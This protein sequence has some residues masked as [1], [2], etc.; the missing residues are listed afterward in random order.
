MVLELDHAPTRPGF[1]PLSLEA[2]AAAAAQAITAVTAA[3]SRDRRGA[4]PVETGRTHIA[5]SEGCRGSDSASG[6]LPYRAAPQRGSSP[7]STTFT[8]SG[9]IDTPQT[10]C[11]PWV[12][13]GRDDCEYE[14]DACVAVSASAAAAASTT[15]PPREFIVAM[16]NLM[17][18]FPCLEQ[19][20]A[21]LKSA[22]AYM[23]VLQV[24]KL[25]DHGGATIL[26]PRRQLPGGSATGSSPQ[27]AGQEDPLLTLVL[28]LDETLVHCRLECLEEPRHDFCVKF[29]ESSA[30]GYV[31]VRP[32]ARLFLDI[33]A[34]LFE[35]VVFTASSRGYADQ[36]LDNL[37][38]DG[39]C[40]AA[41]LYRQHCTEVQGAYLK[42]VRRLGRP[43][44]RIV[45]VDNS[46]VSLTL[47]PDNGIIVKGW[48]A[49][50]GEDSELM[51]LLLVLHQLA[52]S[53][54]PEVFLKHRYGLDEFFQAIRRQPELIGRVG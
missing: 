20:P 49:E 35:V 11:P 15:S 19:Y 52:Q 30:V 27:Y 22:L 12:W 31:Y 21:G 33:V 39:T 13:T 25:P 17:E 41:R 47:C 16:P 3:L 6:S 9:N 46:P 48:H 51:D 2:T 8:L 14:S 26:P 5:D 1:S 45:L 18:N 53:R 34:R 40:I 42:D 10:P 50:K 28:D 32:F 54:S 24:P 37:D 29:E 44:S 38:P 7:L 23:T 4:N 36:V 43:V